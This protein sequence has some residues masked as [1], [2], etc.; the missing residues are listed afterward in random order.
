MKAVESVVRL[1]EKKEQ[2][3]AL[4]EEFER[5]VA[6][7]RA[8]AVCVKGCADCC[9]QVG[10]VAATTL[11]GMVIREH[12]KTW[13]H[14]AL[15]ALHHKLRQNRSD[16]LTQVFARCAFL[17]EDQACTVYPVRPFSCRRL[18]SVKTCGEQGP[19][20]HRRAMALASQ[21]IEVLQDLDPAGCSGHLSLILHLLEKDTFRE[22]Y[23]QGGWNQEKF[24]GLIER[25]QLTVHAEKVRGAEPRLPLSG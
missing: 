9:I 5:R 2:L 6:P 13:S 4:Y 12:L 23:L 17:D 16:K 11:E 14:D 8:Q 10:T 25:Y 1:D 22:V 19:V 21:T 3:I 20:I 15:A 7:F 18:Y 24:R